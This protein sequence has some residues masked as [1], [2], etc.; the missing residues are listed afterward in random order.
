MLVTKTSHNTLPVSFLDRQLAQKRV[1]RLGNNKNVLICTWN[2]KCT[3][4]A[5]IQAI[6]PKLGEITTFFAVKVNLH[7]I[8]R[9]M[10]PILVIFKLW[11]FSKLP[12]LVKHCK[13]AEFWIS[14]NFYLVECGSKNQPKFCLCK[15]SV[16]KLAIVLN[17]ALCS[18]HNII[19]NIFPKN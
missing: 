16:A 4:S 9:L 19:E 12:K 10:E 7:L 18:Q 3:V 8:N 5:E 15:K 11:N 17:A 6:C 1:S 2:R 14:I 13:V